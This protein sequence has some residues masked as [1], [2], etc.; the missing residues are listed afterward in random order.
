[1]ERDNMSERAALLV[2]LQ[3]TGSKWAEVARLVEDRGSALSLLSQESGQ[4]QFGEH[5]TSV[6]QELAGA[7]QQILDW[8]KEGIHFATLLDDD[9]PP[10]L[11]SIH[12]R[13]PFV[14]WTGHQSGADW[15]GVAIVG[16]RIPTEEGA[17]RAR[18]LASELA[19]RGITVVSGLAKGIDAAAHLGALDSGGRTVAVI[20]TGLNISYPRE[21]SSLQRR[22]ASEGMVLSQFLPTSPPSKISFPMRNAIMSG[23]SFATVVIE[24]SEKSGARMQ[25]RLALQHGRPVLLLEQL[26]QHQWARDLGGR[27]GARFVSSIEDIVAILDEAASYSDQLVDS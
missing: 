18:Q 3:R 11:L 5:T 26:R 24:A 1:M 14:T 19:L 12:Q 23:F 2:L 21:N 10:Q 27:P 22:I 16:T 15:R 7:A 9:Y 4:L 20:G 25:A 6:D 8:E 13:P 17:R